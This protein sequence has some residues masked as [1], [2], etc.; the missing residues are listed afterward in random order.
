M[1]T[2]GSF[3]QQ[4]VTTP[5]LCER[6]RLLCERRRLPLELMRLEARLALVSPAEARRWRSRREA[7]GETLSASPQNEPLEVLWDDIQALYKL[8]MAASRRWVAL[9]SP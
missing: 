5:L 9:G 2:P 8:L 1:Q 4:T 3:W 6:Y 7:L